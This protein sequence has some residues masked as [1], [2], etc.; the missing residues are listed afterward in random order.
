MDQVFPLS[1]HNP[2]PF[3]VDPTTLPPAAQRSP[4]ATAAALAIYAGR[5]MS[6]PTLLDRL[7]TLRGAHRGALGDSDQIVDPEYG[8]A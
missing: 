7:S 6:D 3:G 2:A 1:F 8:R 5:S 4:R